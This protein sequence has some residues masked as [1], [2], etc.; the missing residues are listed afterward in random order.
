M[1]AVNI[2]RMKRAFSADNYSAWRMR[3]YLTRNIRAI[4][5]NTHEY[6]PIDAGNERAIASGL[7]AG[8]AREYWQYS[9]YYPD[10]DIT[11]SLRV[12]PDKVVLQLV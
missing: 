12:D 10:A 2:T 7:I 6:I 5:T 1:E 4:D 8:H 3:F 11:A 9:N